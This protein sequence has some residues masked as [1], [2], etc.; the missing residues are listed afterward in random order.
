[1]KVT[2]T[3]ESRTNG[4]FIEAPIRS[5]TGCRGS[6]A[7]A[8]STAYGRPMAEWLLIIRPHRDD[9][10]A[11]MTDVEKECWSRHA[12]RLA[13]LTEEGTVLLAG[14]TLGRVNLGVTVFE[15]DD[16]AAAWEFVNADPTVADGHV[17]PELY[18]YRASFVR[19]NPG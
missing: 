13:R 1:M 11:T 2:F 16:E 12:E 5:R 4:A 9:F 15:A 3:Q 10:A 14:P 18:P 8:A 19:R 17:T 6:G 7:G